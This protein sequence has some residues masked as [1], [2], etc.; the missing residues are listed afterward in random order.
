MK[1]TV[2]SI[3]FDSQY[4]MIDATFGGGKKQERKVFSMEVSK[5]TKEGVKDRLKEE[6]R[7]VKQIRDLE[8]E[9]APLIGKEIEV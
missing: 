3:T 7:K 6:V 1:V 5:A 4:A 8:D 9:V 2:N